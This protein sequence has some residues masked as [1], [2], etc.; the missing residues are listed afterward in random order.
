LNPQAAHDDALHPLWGW[1]L[2]SVDHDPVNE[3][4]YHRDDKVSNFRMFIGLPFASG[5]SFQCASLTVEIL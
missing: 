3:A 4:V 2:V 1:S 5:K